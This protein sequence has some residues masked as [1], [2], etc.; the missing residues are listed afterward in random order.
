METFFAHSAKNGYPPQRYAEHVE[1]TTKLALCF[2]QEMKPY[3]KKDAAQ[4]E[5]ILRCAV[6]YHDL[7]KLDEK[8]QA[9]LHQKDGESGP[10]PVNHT[11]AGAAFLKQ[12][13]RDALCSILLVYAHH[14]GLPDSTVETN[15]AEAACY[16]D[17][18]ET[19]RSYVDQELEQL[20]QLH[21]H[22][23]PESAAHVPEYCEGDPAIFFRMM[24]SCL[25]D[26]DHSDT[27]AAYGQYPKPENV[28]ELQPARRLEAL[29]QYVEG[30]QGAHPSERN[31]LRAQMYKA[32]RDCETKAGIVSNDAPVGSGKTTAIMAHQLRQAMLR[33]ARRIF[34]VLPYTNLITQSVDVY[35]KALVL[36]GEDPE[37]VVAELHHKADFESEDTRYLTSLWRAPIIVTTAV[38]FFE[39]LASNRPST[40]RRLH[41][42]PGSIIFMDEAHAALPVKLLPLAWHWMNVLEEE[43]SCY[44]VLASGSLVRF[45][46]IPE[47]AKLVGTPAKQVP[48][49]VN[50]NLR[51]ALLRY[52]KKRITYCWNSQPLSRAELID[53]VMAQPGPRLLIMNTVQ[54]AAV[55]ADDI[56]K[57]YGEKCVEHLSTALMPVDRA[58]TMEVVKKRLANP[59]DSN[60]VLAATSCVEAGVDF[61]FR[62]GF[63]EL[64][65]LLSLLQ[66]AGRVGRNALYGDAQMW[67]FHMKDDAMLTSHPGIKVRA[68]IL[69]EYL[70]ECLREK[71][72]ITPE[73]STQSIQD[74][75]YRGTSE[76]KEMQ[77]LMEAE[78][79][80]NFQTVNDLFHVIESDTVPVIV[81]AAVAEQIQKGHGN[82]R[83]VQKY[84]VSI[85]RKNLEKWHVKQIAEDVYQWDLHYDPFL[86]YMDGVLNPEK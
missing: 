76:T 43:W 17:A 24:L 22:L 58:K 52:E 34:V 49:M 27:A 70:C 28:P 25:A 48:E 16:R 21:R 15:R 44:W 69:K 59:T 85:R 73:M 60:W 35:R 37:A 62:T 71:K 80:S 65:A 63:R 39:T 72:E 14:H 18:H 8:N 57:K 45:W 61:S 86:G 47:L 23:V 56:R 67:S 6:P 11:D 74:E 77:A 68:A 78:T 29:N 20:L 55:I 12:S 84:A 31:K 75:L 82:W 36:A 10:L 38:A 41:A 81:D 83:E 50:Q 46:Q 42:L 64:A 26:A 51:Q 13:G 5:N 33:G 32:C 7:G 40:L 1:N 79:L 19:V 4:F 54:N 53:W 9:V 66:S 30:L 2:A 3:C